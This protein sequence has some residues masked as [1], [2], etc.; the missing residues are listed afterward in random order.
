MCIR[1]SSAAERLEKEGF[2]VA[3]LPVNARGEA[4]TE[5]LRALL[6]PETGLVAVMAANN[7]TLSLI[8][9]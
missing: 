2:S 8:H 7:E 1:D 4:E 9:I 3:Y 6:T 5:A